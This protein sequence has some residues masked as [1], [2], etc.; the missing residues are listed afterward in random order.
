[1]DIAQRILELRKSKGLSQEELAD[2]LGVTRQAVSKWE[3]G[4]SLPEYDK[5]I[6]L[7]DFFEVST[8]YL[9]KGI[10]P[11]ESKKKR[12]EP[13]HAGIFAMTGSAFTL[14]GIVVAIMGW[15]DEK[16][17]PCV[18]IGII[19]EIMGC[20]IFGVG[21]LTSDPNTVP[22]AKAWFLAL[23]VWIVPFM[24][25]SIFVN[26]I[27]QR[28][29]WVAPYPELLISGR[30]ALFVLTCCLVYAAVCT[31]ASIILLVKI[32]KLK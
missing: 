13:L 16:S 5:L 32:K 15:L 2:Q 29:I 3:S 27:A 28:S 6:L 19:L 9:M 12:K 26:C 31:A 22:S 4:Q 7:S 11:T 21:M 17:L 25:F 8:D 30:S 10:V 23:N 14:M 20:M 1:M 24:P 18:A